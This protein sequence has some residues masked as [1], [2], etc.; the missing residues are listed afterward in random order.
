MPFH[1][2]LTGMRSGALQYDG[3]IFRK[4]AKYSNIFL[5]I[6]DKRRTSGGPPKET[7]QSLNN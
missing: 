2:N 4:T 7:N 6:C 1:K 5:Q 3:F